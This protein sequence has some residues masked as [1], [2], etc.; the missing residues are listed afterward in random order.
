[1]QGV[2]GRFQEEAMPA[3]VFVPRRW[4]PVYAISLG[5]Y[6]SGCMGLGLRVRVYN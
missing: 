2:N 4:S 5:K 3:C 6:I 1:M